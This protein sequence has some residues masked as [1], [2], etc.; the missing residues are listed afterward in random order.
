MFIRVRYVTPGAPRHE[1]DVHVDRVKHEPDRYEVIDKKPV[2]R[3]RPAS[4]VSGVVPK[5]STPSGVKP[6]KKREQKPGEDSTAPTGAD[7]KE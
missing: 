7:S 1:F 3:Q 2:P 6:A 4:H 5:K